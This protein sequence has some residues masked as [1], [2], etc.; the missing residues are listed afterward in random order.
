MA[1]PDLLQL[2]VPR[3]KWQCLPCHAVSKV[4]VPAVEE[5]E[6]DDVGFITPLLS[7]LLVSFGTSD[8]ELEHSRV[9]LGKVQAGYKK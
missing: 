9:Q 5:A 6:E 2:R 3:G 1:V 4:H 7:S 8:G